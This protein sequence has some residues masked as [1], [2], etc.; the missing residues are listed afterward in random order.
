MKKKKIIPTWVKVAAVAALFVPYKVDIDRDEDKKLK[1]LTTCS[2]AVRFSYSPARDGCESDI[3]AV[4]PGVSSEK[5]KVKA[6]GKTYT[7]N[8]EQIIKNAK[9]VCGEV[10]DKVKT[11]AK[12]AADG[13][14]N[15]KG[16][17][18]HCLEEEQ[19]CEEEA[20]AVENAAE[21]AILAEEEILNEEAALDK[22]EADGEPFD[23]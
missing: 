17:C 23:E 22:E 20:E 19:L 2:I 10:A 4:I 3:S 12:K 7:V 5:C 11:F 9:T 15:A 16:G 13:V 8:G 14:A 6:G 1:K 18:K 21:E